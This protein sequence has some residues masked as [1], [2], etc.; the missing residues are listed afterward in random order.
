MF[1]G[2]IIATSILLPF[3]IKQ[4]NYIFVD[5]K[6][7]NQ[8]PSMFYGQNISFTATVES[9]SYLLPSFVISTSE[10]VPL[11]LHWDSPIESPAIT[12]GDRIYFRGTYIN[13]SVMVHEFY[14][15]DY[16]SS[17][18]RSIPGILLFVVMFFMVFKIDFKRIAFVVRT[19][20]GEST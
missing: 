16:S 5:I 12:P 7:V 8:N 13:N 19:G 20:G 4:S 14:V 9:M 1:L 15:L 18:I 3:P 6:L 17:I 11:F 10:G 2:L